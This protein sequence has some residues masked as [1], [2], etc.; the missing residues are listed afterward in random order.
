[1]TRF[2]RGRSHLLQPTGYG[3]RAGSP[4]ISVSAERG[5][6]RLH[7]SIA[8][9]D[10]FSCW[11]VTIEPCPA[12]RL[13]DLRQRADAAARVVDLFQALGRLGEIAS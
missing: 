13:R 5:R 2:Y 3:Y 8:R 1:M 7:V 4:G 10:G 6:R 9:A 11:S 12:G